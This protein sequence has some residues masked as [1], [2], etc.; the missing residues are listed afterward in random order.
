MH[1]GHVGGHVVGSRSGW[2][3]RD[4]PLEGWEGG[5]RT[6]P[7]WTYATTL[8]MRGLP[9]RWC[10]VLGADR[11]EF[12]YG[13]AGGMGKHE[14]I[15][16]CLESEGVVVDLCGGEGDGVG[17]PGRAPCGGGWY[18]VNRLEESLCR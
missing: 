3:Q 15:W 7:I 12:L 14:D 4:P 9:W 10:E 11:I 2:L 18:G 8:P 13:R 1:Q 5:A 17:L 6:V 16:F